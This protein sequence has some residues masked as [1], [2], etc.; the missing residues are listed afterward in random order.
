MVGEDTHVTGSGCDVNLSHIR[1][2]KDCLDSGLERPLTRNEVVK[3]DA[4]LVGENE[5]QFYFIRDLRVATAS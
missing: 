4:N 3:P 5:R 2:S 1:G